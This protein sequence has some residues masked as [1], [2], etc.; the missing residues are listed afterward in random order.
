[1]REVSLVAG[2]RLARSIYGLRKHRKAVVTGAA[3]LG[4]LLSY[5]VLKAFVQPAS[6]MSAD[7]VAAIDTE[8]GSD[9]MAY[10]C[11]H[12]GTRDT[13]ISSVCQAPAAVAGAVAAQIQP[14]AAMHAGSCRAYDA[15]FRQYAWNVH[16]AEAICQAESGGNPTAVSRTNDYGLMQ[17]HNMKIVDPVQNIAAAYRKYQTQGWDAWTTYTVGSYARFL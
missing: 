12:F 15:L 5:S 2:R 3:V 6:A 1:M 16:V 7:A 13:S 10:Y 4:C 17:L 14:A 9:E 11:A 8:Y